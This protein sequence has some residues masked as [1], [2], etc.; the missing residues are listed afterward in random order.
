MG[1]L[2]AWLADFVFVYVFAAVACARGLAAMRFMGIGIVP[3]ATLLSTLAAAVVTLVLMRIAARRIHRPST[4]EHSR[5]IAFVA[6]ATSV[7]GLIAAVWLA[8]PA[9]LIA[10]CAGS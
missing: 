7:L 3:L 8:L 5:F 4:D 6:F 10:A 1:S 9:L 2:L